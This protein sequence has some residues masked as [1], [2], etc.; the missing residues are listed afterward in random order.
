MR[1]YASLI[2]V[3]LVGAGMVG[4]LAW[5]PI[6]IPN[7]LEVSGR[8]LPV[9]AWLLTRDPNGH[10]VA[11]LHSHRA[12]A[13]VAYTAANVE[14]GDLV[15]LSVDPALL[16]RGHVAAGDTVGVLLSGEG[17]YALAQLAGQLLTAEATVRLYET[18][19][20]APLIEEARQRLLRLEEEHTRQAKAVARQ[21]ELHARALIPDEELEL[22]TS[23]LRQM[24]LAVAEA[25]AHLEAVQ[26][27]ARPEQVALARAQVQALRDEMQALRQRLARNTFVAPISGPILHTASPDTL[28]TVADTSGYVVV[29]PVRWEDRA[30]VAVGQEV[31]IHTD[32]G[33]VS[34][35]IVHR[36]PAARLFGESAWLLVTA[37]VVGS[38]GGLLTPGLRVR[39]TVPAAPLSPL[40]W[41]RETWGR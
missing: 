19:E 38:P 30:R 23:T 4:V 27:G 11:T 36:D 20:K 28:L 29:L 33:T 34:A 6:R 24:A 37:E 39:C 16:Q 9:Q 35:R 32:A 12:G 8:V 40:A 25:Q 7:G 1:T 17:V 13:V 15:D 2:L 3:L 22:G 41:V 18:G 10:L 21:Q 26:T 31:R 5:L 14:R